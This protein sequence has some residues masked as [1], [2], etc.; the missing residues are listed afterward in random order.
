MYIFRINSPHRSPHQSHI[1]RIFFCLFDSYYPKFSYFFHKINIF[2]WF[3]E[4]KPRFFTLHVNTERLN[5]FQRGGGGRM[6]F[7]VIGNIERFHI[8]V[9]SPNT[10]HS[11]YKLYRVTV[12]YLVYCRSLSGKCGIQIRN[13]DSEKNYYKNETIFDI[14]NK[15]ISG[16]WIKPGEKAC[17][18][19]SIFP[20]P[21][22]NPWN[23]L[24]TWNVL[25]K[26]YI[27]LYTWNVFLNISTPVYLE[28]LWLE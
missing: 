24:N 7:L 12:H 6:I 16:I 11:I 3:S 28:W 1:K 27:S 23:P 5:Y 17:Q 2:P 8:F 18:L 15:L 19:V 14:K 4:K 21:P 22:P 10:K 25:H 13:K 9:F 20:F 26:I